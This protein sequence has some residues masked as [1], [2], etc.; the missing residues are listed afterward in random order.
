MGRTHRLQSF[1]QKHWLEVAFEAFVDLIGGSRRP[2]VEGERPSL[3]APVSSKYQEWDPVFDAQ[4]SWD[5]LADGAPCWVKARADSTDSWS[6]EEG[7]GESSFG[8][9][10]GSP[11]G[12]AT[13]GSSP[14]ASSID[15]SS[16]SGSLQ[17]TALGLSEARAPP[18]SVEDGQLGIAMVAGRVK[19]LQQKELRRGRGQPSLRGPNANYYSLLMSQQAGWGEGPGEGGGE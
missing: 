13:G 11:G 5:Q 14:M 19:E 1:W 8:S 6:S 16:L 9:S 12:S 4:L 7:V 17:A 15:S 10:V 18:H 3:A 2:S